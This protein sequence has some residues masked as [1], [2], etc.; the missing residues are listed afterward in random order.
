MIDTRFP[1]VSS[2]SKQDQSTPGCT[3]LHDG[4]HLLTNSQS[5]MSSNS[6]PTI[7][8]SPSSKQ[9]RSTLGP[10]TPLTTAAKRRTPLS[11]LL[12][13]P[14]TIHRAG[15]NTPRTGRARVLTSDE[16]LRLLKEKEVKKKQV[17]VE[18]E[19]RKEDRELKK[20]QREQE[21]KQ[22]AEEKAKKA[23]EREAAKAKKEA[24]RTEKNASKMKTS[25]STAASGTKR[26]SPANQRQ[27]Q[28]KARCE[29]DETV[30][31]NLCCVCFGSFDSCLH[32]SIEIAMIISWEDF[33]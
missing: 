16:C 28:K 14:E 30:H 23:A 3:S 20:K 1:C 12:N 6:S 10:Q 19:K 31:E 26:N 32:K 27:A 29:I 11:S 4:S 33:T 5:P 15:S 17:Q 8:V 24:A 7:T 21:Q 2:S 18:K 25:T 13:L 22:K 9:D